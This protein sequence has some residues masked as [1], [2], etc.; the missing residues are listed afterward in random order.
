MR[1]FKDI[2]VLVVLLFIS[3]SC[4]K[5]VN[6]ADGQYVGSVFFPLVEGYFWVY[7]YTWYD[8]TGKITD[9]V[10]DTMLVSSTRIFDNETWYGIGAGSLLFANRSDGLY[11][12]DT[13]LSFIAP[14]LFLKYPGRAGDLWYN[15][16]LG[17]SITI[18]STAQQIDVLGIVKKCYKYRS[19]TNWGYYEDYSVPG[20]GIVFDEVFSSSF[21]SGRIYKSSQMKLTGHSYIDVRN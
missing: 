3:I 20:F 4:E 17:D 16:V 12:R 15:G 9:V 19:K 7:E 11:I 14:Q 8:T 21:Y 13:S 5:G 6:F 2:A 1:S 18:I 10:I